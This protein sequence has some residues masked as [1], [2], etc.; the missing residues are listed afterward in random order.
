MVEN[1]T[2][3]RAG[4]SGSPLQ[5]LRRQQQQLA[6]ASACRNRLRELRVML[7]VQVHG[8]LS[9][10]AWYSSLSRRTV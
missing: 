2:P 4:R 8:A 1:R 6:A 10:R 5:Q 3:V 9:G 7:L